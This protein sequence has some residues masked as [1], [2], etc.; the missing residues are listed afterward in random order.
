V[1]YFAAD[2]SSVQYVRWYFDNKPLRNLGIYTL[3]DERLILVK[4]SEE[5]A[6]LFTEQTWFF[7]GPVDYRV[8]Q[9]EYLSPW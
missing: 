9:G 8:S 6:F 2:V 3:H 5:V 4:R 1:L 7:Y